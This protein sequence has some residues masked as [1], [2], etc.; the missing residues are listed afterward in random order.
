MATALSTIEVAGFVHRWGTLSVCVLGDQHL[1]DL[2]GAFPYLRDFGVPHHSLDW[3][4]TGVT[5]AA[6]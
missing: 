2:I 5:V 6:V 3:I 1:L 4:V